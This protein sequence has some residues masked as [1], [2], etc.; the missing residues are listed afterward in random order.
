LAHELGHLHKFHISKRKKSQKKINNI[1]NFTNLSLI[2]SSLLLQN[3]RYLLE[4]M[5]TNQVGIQNYYLSF[6]REQE[7]EADNY[8]IETLDKLNLS[9]E[10]LVK[11]LE[12]LEKNSYQKGFTEEYFKFSTHPIFKERYKI[13][14]NSSN[15]SNFNFNKDLDN[16]FNFVKAKIY[17][18]T[19]NDL[20][21]PEEYL[22]KEFIT[23]AKSIILS[24]NGELKKSMKSLNSLLKLYPNNKFILETKADILYSNGFL[25]EAL[26]FYEKVSASYPLNNYV[27][28]R[29]FDIKFTTNNI[30]EYNMSK[31]LFDENSYLLLIFYNNSDLNL[32]FRELAKNNFYYDWT[33]YFMIIEKFYNK[34]FYK[35]D[36]KKNLLLINDKTSDKIL[37][38]LIKKYLSIIDEN[39]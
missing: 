33:N 4:S 13:I 37:K 20:N 2:A 26:L 10:P 5:I 8:G 38:K 23:Y 11:F 39:S 28:S 21:T 19:E 9:K 16:R 3:N 7:R 25:S 29:I 35:N 18:F 36:L 6:S 31:M 22:K 27:K 24:K 30:K 15:K 17:G 12:L 32:K 34:E 14:K 1:N